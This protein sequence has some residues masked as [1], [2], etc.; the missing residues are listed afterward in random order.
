[1]FLCVQFSLC[2]LHITEHPDMSISTPY[3][4]ERWQKFLDISGIKKWNKPKYCCGVVNKALFRLCGWLLGPRKQLLMKKIVTAV[5]VGTSASVWQVVYWSDFEAQY[6]FQGVHMSK[7]LP[8]YPLLAL[9]I[10]LAPPT[11]S[12]LFCSL[13][14][15]PRWL[16]DDQSSSKF[17][18]SG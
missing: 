6:G 2:H 9:F 1:M 11:S 15:R 7:R 14:S 3:L 4:R 13:P 12:R 10:S 17:V 16:A 18:N 8:N 5:W